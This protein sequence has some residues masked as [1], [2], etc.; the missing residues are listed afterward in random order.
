MFSYVSGLRINISKSEI[1]PVGNA[2]NFD[3]LASFFLAARLLS[4]YILSRLP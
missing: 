2:G 1:L 4:F 3:S